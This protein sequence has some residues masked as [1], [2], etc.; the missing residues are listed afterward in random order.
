MDDKMK[1]EQEDADKKLKERIDARKSRKSILKT[2]K[3]DGD[4]VDIVDVKDGVVLGHDVDQ[5]EEE[6]DDGN[7]EEVKDDK[8]NTETDVE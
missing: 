8:G 5:D 6:K 1:Q 2:N 3:D 4:A 7:G